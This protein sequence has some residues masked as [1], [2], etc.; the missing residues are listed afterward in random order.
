[1][2]TSAHLKLCFVRTLVTYKLQTCPNLLPL[3]S[4][5]G[6]SSTGCVVQIIYGYPVMCPDPLVESGAAVLGGCVV[7]T[8]S[9]T[10]TC[11]ECSA[12]GGKLTL[13]RG[14]LYLDS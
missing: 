14:E 10:Y 1:M 5:N 13:K 4:S 8:D 2:R 9:P 7:G 6:K 3:C 12:K 11:K